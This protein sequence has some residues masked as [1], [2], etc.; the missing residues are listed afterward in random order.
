MVAVIM[1]PSPANER[2]IKA[3]ILGISGSGAQLLEALRAS[4]RIDLIALA[5]RDGDLAKEVATELHIEGYDDYRSLIVEQPMEVLYVAAA[6]FACFDQLKLAASR[7]IHVWRETPLARTVQE[8]TQL[9][10]VFDARKV[11]L[12]VARP[13]RFIGVGGGVADPSEF[14]GHPYVARG[15]VLDYRPDPLNW[16]G[17]HERAGG[18]ALIDQAYEIVDAIV[19]WMGLPDQV[20]STTARRPGVQPYD[21]EDVAS[22]MLRYRDGAMATLVAHRRTFPQAWSLAFDGP[23]GSLLMEPGVTVIQTADGKEIRQPRP[24]RKS[25]HIAQIESFARSIL[26]DAKS[27]SS[28]AREHLATVAVIETAYLSARTGEPESPAKLY[29]LHD[30]PLPGHWEGEV[31][32]EAEEGREQAER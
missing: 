32:S 16:R 14:I 18:G 1:D 6:P 25:I 24:D 3:G 4:E 22:V 20:V 17:D 10:E 26:S 29:D 8:A 27:Y 13:W 5:D 9:L 11:R 19:Q 28:A 12:A 31:E 30:L 15:T 7:G 21:T 23:K 2:R